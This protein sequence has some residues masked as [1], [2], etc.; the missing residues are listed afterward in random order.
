MAALP[1]VMACVDSRCAQWFI[2]GSHGD[3]RGE[4]LNSVAGVCRVTFR[5]GQTAHG[6]TVVFGQRSFE[7][8][9]ENC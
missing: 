3:H 1:S 8:R 6:E 9:K 5:Q 4:I 7:L 2:W